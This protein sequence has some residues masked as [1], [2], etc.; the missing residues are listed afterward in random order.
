MLSQLKSF[1]NRF[2]RKSPAPE[3]PQE[4]AIPA[5]NIPKPSP[6][7]RPATAAAPAAMPKPRPAAAPAASETSTA[8]NVG[9]DEVINL[10]AKI[11]VSR[12][13][14]ALSAL[15]KAPGDGNIALPARKVLEQLP[16]GS[17]KLT[18]AELRE[19]APPG[20]FL[21][22]TSQDQTLVE[23]PLP[24][25]LARVKP[26]HLKR[27]PA[28]RQVE[29]PQDVGNVFGPRGE[30][31]PQ[32]TGDTGMARKPAAAPVQ[33][34]PVAPAKPIPVPAPA[35]K[36]SAPAPIKMP[37]PSMPKTVPAPQPA[38]QETAPA[39][40]DQTQFFLKKEAV[41]AGEV[42][43][44]S[45]ASIS[46]S[47]PQNIKQEISAQKLNDS[48]VALP[49]SKVESALKTGKIIFAWQEIGSWLKPAAY[50]STVNPDAALELPLKVVAPLFISQHRPI[51]PQKKVDLGEN[52]P[53]IFAGGKL[54]AAAPT[55]EPP[56]TAPAPAPTPTPA[57]TG[58]APSLPK[59][60]AASSTPALPKAPIAMPSVPKAT[61][62]APALPKLPTPSIPKPAG[63]IP[64]PL[65][66]LA[67]TVAPAVEKE[68]QSLGE[69]FG[70]PNKKDWS[71]NDVVQ[72]T[73][74]LKGVAGSMV[75]LSDGLMVAGELPAPF[76]AET[77]AAFLP[78][79]FGR[80]GNYAKELHLGDMNVIS[81]ECQKAPLIIYKSG[82]VF[83]GVLGRAGETLPLSQIRFIAAELAKQNK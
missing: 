49:M 73:N 32:P 45:L 37:V 13:P 28:Q 26:E 67:P 40:T 80:M 66:K 57:A 46:E 79:I 25:I 63:P 23:L 65:P 52:I 24:E 21:D 60:P 54:K 8:I 50:S 59:P 35:A 36:A 18:F 39:A 76:R 83:F 10:P 14:S 4:T 12:L 17:V 11:I 78:Q 33:P 82:M 44:V 20:T 29:V 55:P 64:V 47:W 62:T 1:L 22:V 69:L 71:P 61:P 31:L 58:P 81:F 19:A 7:T 53:D 77:T 30:Q 6:P 56:S 16:R 9:P 43:T 27:K 75:S 70:N 68:P 42:L 38:L 34:R 72:G 51:S 48:S 3:A 41:P 5:P 2:S 15:V 74:K